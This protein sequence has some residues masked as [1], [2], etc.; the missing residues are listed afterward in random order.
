VDGRVFPEER[1]TRWKLEFRRY[2]A[3]RTEEDATVAPTNRLRYSHDNVTR[4]HRK[5]NT[6]TVTYLLDTFVSSL[7][8]SIIHSISNELIN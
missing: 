7:E 8:H 3:R 2:Q 5:S 6:K 1:N 4:A